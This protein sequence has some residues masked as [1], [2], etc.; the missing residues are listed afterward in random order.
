MLTL[1]LTAV[2]AQDF[3]PAPFPEEK[4]PAPAV[5]ATPSEPMAHLPPKTVGGVMAPA[6]LPSGSTALYALLGAPD[7][8]GG[9]R[10]GFSAFEFEAHLLFNYL[11][12]SGVLEASA[13][14]PIYEKG[15]LQM[16]PVIGLGLEADSGSRYYDKANF[17]FFAIRPRLGFLTSVRFSDTVMGLFGVDVPWAIPVA[18][19]GGH[20]TPGLQAGFEAYLGGNISGLVMGELGL[21]AIK[22]PLGVT[23]YR[24]LWGIR[25]GLGFRLF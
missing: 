13:K 25:L 9:Y 12:A 14:I 21:D 10:Q 11:L 19:S 6:A 3:A 8:G 22:M 23:Q 7:I 2:L 15:K 1:L 24:P 5:E 17:S 18:S 16:A 20:V 4:K